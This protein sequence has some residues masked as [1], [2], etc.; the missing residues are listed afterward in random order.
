MRLVERRVP[1]SSIRV[2]DYLASEETALPSAYDRITNVN[3]SYVTGDVAVT[4]KAGTVRYRLTGLVTIF[5]EE[6]A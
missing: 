6:L 2:G 3:V 4:T 1:A 5:R